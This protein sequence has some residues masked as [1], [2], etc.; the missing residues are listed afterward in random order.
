MSYRAG[1]SSPA[2]TLALLLS[3][4]QQMN[5]FPVGAQPTPSL[6]E[7]PQLYSP[8]PHTQFPVSPATQQVPGARPGPG[9]R[10]SGLGWPGTSL[11]PGLAFSTLPTSFS[12]PPSPT[13]C[14][15][16]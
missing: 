8:A 2:L 10:A 12:P 5:P 4:P 7:P 3:R 13:R 9:L 15:Q 1:D 11:N 6:Q 16:R 14:G